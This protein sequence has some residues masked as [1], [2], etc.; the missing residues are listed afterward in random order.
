MKVNK[1]ATPTGER[2][3]AQILAAAIHEFAEYGL[4]GGRVDRI[5][6]TAGVN[7]QAIYYY[8]R[9]KDELFRAALIFGY[10]THL[11]MNE[12]D[13]ANDPRSAPELMR[14][15][16]SYFFDLIANNMDHAALTAD[17]N[18]HRGRHLNADSLKQIR[19]CTK[20]SFD[21][22]RTVLERGKKAKD[23]KADLD[24]R[25]C[26]FFVVGNII[27][28]VNHRFTLSGIFGADTLAP[29]NF[30]KHKTAFASFVVSALMR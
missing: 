18:R 26:F 11:K 13:W 29:R 15:Y 2:T 4:A 14:F 30:K 28:Y 1:R 27:F 24:T 20:V 10:N 12:V 25:E 9:D 5:A 16:V 22:F 21:A 3:K 23:F 17:E 19:R 6:G 7:K 8:F